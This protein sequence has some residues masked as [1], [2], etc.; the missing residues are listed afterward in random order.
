[1]AAERDPMTFDGVD[2]DRWEGGRGVGS[3]QLL[4]ALA[5][6]VLLG[7]LCFDYVLVA[8]G[9]PT[10][11]V[12]GA[13]GPG[14]KAAVVWDVSS[15]EWLFAGVLLLGL[16][17]IAVPLAENRRMTAYYWRQFR[18]NG[19]AV[20]SLG[21]L[22]LLFLVG[23]V[24]PII[25]AAP[26]ETIDYASAYA[27]PLGMGGGLGS[28]EHALGTDAQGRHIWHLIV[29]GIR[30]SFEVGLIATALAISIGTVVGAVAAYAGGYVDEILMRY[31]D[32]QQTFP[33]F[34]LL[35]LIIYLYGASLL[36]IILLYGV[37]G[38]EGIARLV[39][40]EALQRSEQAYT[41]AAE[42]AG[43]SRRWIVRRHI[44]PNVS[45][46]VIT[47]ATL[48]IPVFILGEA[49]LSF[50]GFGDPST[51]SWGRTISAGR[52]DLDSAWWISTIPGLFLFLT[53]LAFNF[54]GD[55][56]R[57]ATDPRSES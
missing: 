26:N 15:V 16:F 1:M 46:T 45:S 55:A 47:A 8:P 14:A 39:R 29:Y 13:S 5:G 43:A 4:E 2:W 54:V 19:L 17:H 31:V 37:F 51:F 32:L 25:W 10:I 57:D 50:L 20:V 42:A 48:S 49:T 44:I 21:Y 33:V 22:G 36:L 11:A 53:V 52:A 23:V 34:I 6:L 40:S 41:R 24:G 27:P 7:A 28:P 35:L 30:V 18:K 3:V 38:W 56:L 9:E 12:G